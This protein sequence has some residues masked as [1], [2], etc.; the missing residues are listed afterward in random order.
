MERKQSEE[1]GEERYAERNANGAHE[2][3]RGRDV[4]K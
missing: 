1:V 2:G 3:E 4:E